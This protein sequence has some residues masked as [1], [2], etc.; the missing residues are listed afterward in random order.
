MSPLPSRVISHHQ[1]WLFLQSDCRPSP[2]PKNSPIQKNTEN[3][4]SSGERTRSTGPPARFRLEAMLPRRSLLIRPLRKRRAR[5]L[6]RPP[7]P[8][9]NDS[10]PLAPFALHF[11][12]KNLC[13]FPL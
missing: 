6:I 8:S 1:T 11:H 5:P 9:T 12:P 3:I 4:P 10:R 7:P 2:S 13:N